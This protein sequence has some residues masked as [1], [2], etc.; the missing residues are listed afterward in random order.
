MSSSIPAPGTNTI[1]PDRI[2]R[3]AANAELA[4]LVARWMLKHWDL[5]P[6][7]FRSAIEMDLE[8]GYAGTDTT[9]TFAL[10]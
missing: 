10:Q 6:A 3:D 1:A 5:I 7:L 8:E 4:V 9:V 2:P